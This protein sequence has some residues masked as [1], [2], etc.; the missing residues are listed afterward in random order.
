M[1]TTHREFFDELAPSWEDYIS[2]LDRAAVGTIVASMGILPGDRV[3]DLGS[4]TG[5]AIPALQQWVKH[6]GRVVALD[7]SGQMLEEARVLHGQVGT[8]YVQA[9]GS[10]LPFRDETFDALLCNA[11]FPHLRDKDAALREIGRVLRP[12]GRVYIAHLV[13]RERTNAIHR[14]AGGVIGQDLVPDADE[15]KLMLEA[16]GFSD[17]TVAD[18]PARYVAVGR[19]PV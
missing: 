1:P 15:M 2:P 19:R 14:N 13:G 12:G 10:A 18:E 7:I 16:A 9:D 5:V 11:T 8:S 4:G 3:L 6:D 17:V